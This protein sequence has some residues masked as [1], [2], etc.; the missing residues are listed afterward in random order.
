MAFNAAF[1]R[2]GSRHT[3]MGYFDFDEYLG[4]PQK[5]FDAAA[6]KG[7]T[8]LHELRESMEDPETFIVQNRW[9]GIF[10]PPAVLQPLTTG[11]LLDRKLYG[12]WYTDWSARSK[13]FVKSTDVGDPHKPPYM[14]GNHY[15]C[16]LRDKDMIGPQRSILQYSGRCDQPQLG[17]NEILRLDPPQHYSLHILNMKPHESLLDF[18][19]ELMLQ[20]ML[21]NNTEV[22]HIH[23]LLN[24]AG[25]Q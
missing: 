6:Q 23:E 12:G 2:Y 18:D 1:H 10:P 17:T 8:P 5:Y 20:Q 15:I 22:T 14:I 21:E 7:T 4:L 16:K 9:F 13:F 25:F 19:S 3:Y 11:E 24:R